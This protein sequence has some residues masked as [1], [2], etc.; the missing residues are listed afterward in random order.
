MNITLSA[1]LEKR[2]RERVEC[3]DYA[4][5]DALIDQALNWFLHIEDDEGSEE[6]R[7]A[8][9][10][11]RDQSSRGEALPAAEVFSDLRARYGLSR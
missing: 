3:G 1:E 5:A 8:I 10:E 11:A 4:N 7:A 2:V 6:A 9:E